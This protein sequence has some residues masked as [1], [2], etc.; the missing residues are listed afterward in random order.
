M[1]IPQDTLAVE[2]SIKC[3]TLPDMPQPGLNSMPGSSIALFV[4]AA[5]CGFASPGTS[6]A[7]LAD[8]SHSL[9]LGPFVA[10]LVRAFVSMVLFII[11]MHSLGI[12]CCRQISDYNN[13]QWWQ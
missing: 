9:T 6:S 8:C 10:M 2:S 13:I 11:A 7:F 12:L 1:V 5:I 4:I 3:A